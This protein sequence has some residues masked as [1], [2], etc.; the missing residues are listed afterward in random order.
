MHVHRSIGTLPFPAASD[1]RAAT[2]FAA[3]MQ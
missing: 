3:M 1:Y 2:F